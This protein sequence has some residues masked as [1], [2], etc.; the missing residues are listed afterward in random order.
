M[1]PV[2]FPETVH[3]WVEVV[4]GSS[5]CSKGFFSGYSLLKTNISKFQF[6]LESEGHRFVA[7][8]RSCFFC[9]L[10]ME[11]NKSWLFLMLPIMLGVY[12]S[13]RQCSGLQRRRKQ[14]CLLR[15][16]RKTSFRPFECLCSG[17]IDGLKPSAM[18]FRVH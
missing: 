17:N 9:C 8:F 10:Q 16:L 18:H 12:T 3:M 7:S 14:P 1:A 13:S 15:H 4:V 11:S 5:P 2:R 6:D